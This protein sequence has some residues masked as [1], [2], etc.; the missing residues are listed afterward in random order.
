MNFDEQTL[1]RAFQNTLILKDHTSYT[2]LKSLCE[3]KNIPLESFCKLI[4]WQYQNKNS[5]L[6]GVTK[7][8]DEVLKEME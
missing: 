1:D 3:E 2:I 4:I 5:K 8:I 6:I 7:I